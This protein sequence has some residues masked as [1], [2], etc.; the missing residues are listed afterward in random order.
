MTRD[1]VPDYCRHPI[2][3][4]IVINIALDFG[5]KEKHTL[6]IEEYEIVVEMWP[7]EHAL[8]FRNVLFS[9]GSHCM[10]IL[11]AYDNISQSDPRLTLFVITDEHHLPQCRLML[12]QYRQVIPNF[13]LT[14]L[15]NDNGLDW[16]QRREP[17]TRDPL[18]RQ[19][20][21][22]AKDDSSTHQQSL[23]VVY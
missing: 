6:D 19:H 22:C 4:G 11:S 3:R 15:I 23:V 12:G 8:K 7:L 17:T 5:W 18:A 1:K 20:A 16:D 2:C 10:G 21:D 9:I 13:N 14:R